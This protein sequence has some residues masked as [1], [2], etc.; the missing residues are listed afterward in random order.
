MTSLLATLP[1]RPGLPSEVAVVGLIQSEAE[2]AEL[3]DLATIQRWMTHFASRFAPKG[4]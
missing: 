1:A 2:L 4:F 3:S